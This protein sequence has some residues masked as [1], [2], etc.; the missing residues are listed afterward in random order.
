[1]VLMIIRE[2]IKKIIEEATGVFEVLVEAPK[3]KNYGDYSTNVAL[4]LAKKLNKNPLDIAKEIIYKI[5]NNNLFEKVELAGPGFINFY[6]S[7]TFF[8]NGIREILKNKNFGRSG[9]L[10]NKK[11]FVE[12]TDP[13][14]L[15]E[16]HI[17]HLM[18]NSIGEAISRV[19]EYRAAKVK[20]LCYQGDVG[21]HVAKAVFGRLKNSDYSW[22]EAY[23]F[24]SDNYE[25]DENS[26]K[27]IVELNKKIFEKSDK[28]INKLYDDGKK[29]SLDNFS[30]IYDRL[31]TKFDYYFFESEV[32]EFGKKIVL[33]NQS[34]QNLGAP[35]FEKG[36]K[37]AIIF[38]GEKFGFHTRVFINSEGLPTYE[39][40]EL[41]LAKIK[42]DKYKYDKSIIIT[43]NEQN[44]YFKV[45]LAA[46]SEIFPKL[47]EKTTQIGHG[48][49]RLPE[50]KMSSRTGNVVT[51]ESLINDLKTRLIDKIKDRHLSEKEKEN[52]AEEVAIGAVKY[53]ILRQSIGSDII[54]DFE[55]SISFEGD[56]GPYL[57]YSYVRAKSVLIKAKKEGIKCDANIPMHANDAN[58]KITDLERMM[59]YFS[60][61]VERAGQEYDPHYI[62]L[63]LTELAREFNNYYAHNK[64]VDKE[65]DLSPYRLALTK[66]FSIIMKNGLWLLGIPA[67]ERM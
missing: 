32:S 25:K 33:K 34:A 56:S 49:M 18:S 15:K 36:A 52:I 46:L 26:K 16:F 61:V 59:H 27:E 66:A 57:Q 58:Y 63:Y 45:V 53:S 43:A 13:N 54:Y 55:K 35:V 51:A 5:G 40:K 12:Y 19:I 17:G 22:Q 47:A 10:K 60:E 21:L 48:I 50:G 9:G 62:V 44:E 1:M 24:G 64:I 39:A 8:T 6:L 29:W 38:K 65:D 23:V 14:I 31:G 11:I 37:G 28:D 67:P 30:K 20:R 2:K 4:V 42:F 41:G 3:E 7:K